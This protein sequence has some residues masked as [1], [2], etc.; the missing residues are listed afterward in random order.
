MFKKFFLFL[1]FIIIL[2]SILI[3]CKRP[4]YIESEKNATVVFT[5]KDKKIATDNFKLVKKSNITV[6]SKLTEEDLFWGSFFNLEKNIKPYVTEEYLN[7][8]IKNRL[9]SLY[10]SYAIKNDLLLSVEDIKLN[11]DEESNNLRTK[12]SYLK[13]YYTID[14]E[15]S[16]N[17]LKVKTL[18]ENGTIYFSK[19]EGKILLSYEE[20]NPAEDFK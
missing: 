20:F 4:V 7:W 1:C 5:E 6:T 17:G 14:I 11:F 2:C 3:S 18:S 9:A 15:T 16:K 13:A 10:K 12:S 19:N 8:Y